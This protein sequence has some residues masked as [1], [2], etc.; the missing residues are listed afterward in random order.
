MIILD[1]ILYID[2]LILDGIYALKNPVLD[3]LMP[4]I[5]AFGNSGAVWILI[6]ILCLIFK[7]TRKCGITIA[8]GL[9]LSLI[10]CNGLLKNLVARIRPFEANGIMELLIDIPKDF[11]FPSGHSSASF[12]AASV[13]YMYYKKW[14]I[15]ALIFA[16]LIAF[17]RLYLYV[18]YPS[19]VIFGIILGIMLSFVS[20]YFVNKV[21]NKLK[22]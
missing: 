8:I 1:I 12:V 3:F 2:N 17:S 15:F 22:Q 19:D 21:E 9:I 6:C 10:V 20:R 14:G 13:I 4:I 5:T 16:A 18:H 11:S 7:K